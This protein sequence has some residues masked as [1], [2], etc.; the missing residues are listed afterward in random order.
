[1]EGIVTNTIH[2]YPPPIMCCILPSLYWLW[3]LTVYCLYCLRI[4][5]IKDLI[6]YL[7]DIDIHTIHTDKAHI[8]T[9]P[10][11]T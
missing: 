7:S 3:S 9:T 5:K 4:I 1:M 2:T 11:Q 8:P 10:H 6:F